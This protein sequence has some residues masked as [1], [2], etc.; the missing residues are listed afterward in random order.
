M[1]CPYD[2]FCRGPNLLGQ[3]CSNGTKPSLVPDIEQPSDD[4]D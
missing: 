3:P 2:L 1:E 4:L